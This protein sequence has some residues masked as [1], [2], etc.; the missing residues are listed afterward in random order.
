MNCRC[1]TI[2]RKQQDFLGRLAEIGI[3]T[4][5]GGK[6]SLSYRILFYPCCENLDSDFE[7]VF[8]TTELSELKACRYN[9][10][11]E[12]IAEWFPDDVLMELSVQMEKDFEKFRYRYVEEMPQGCPAYQQLMEDFINAI[13]SGTERPYED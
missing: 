11:V 6:N 3:E 10:A 4:C 1:K 9:D 2:T 7:K 12:F 8:G 13:C 5:L